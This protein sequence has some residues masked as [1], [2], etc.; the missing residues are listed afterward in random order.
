MDIKS[1]GILIIRKLDNCRSGKASIGTFHVIQLT[2]FFPYTCWAPSSWRGFNQMF[3]P[4]ILSVYISCNNIRPIYDSSQTSD[5]YIMSTLDRGDQIYTRRY[6]SYPILVCVQY[7][8]TWI[9]EFNLSNLGFGI[10][11]VNFCF[12]PLND[13]LTMI[14]IDFESITIVC[15]R[16]EKLTGKHPYDTIQ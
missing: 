16:V 7:T 4:R 14:N 13:V 6:M 5:I 15:C 1:T 8:A 11:F 3:L 9:Y 10:K 2:Y 12:T